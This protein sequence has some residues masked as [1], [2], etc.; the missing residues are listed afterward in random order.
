MT[1]LE[2]IATFFCCVWCGQV[3]ALVQ[4]RSTILLLAIKKILIL[5]RHWMSGFAIKIIT[6]NDKYDCPFHSNTIIIHIYI[7]WLCTQYY[8]AKWVKAFHWFI[9]TP[10]FDIN[11]NLA[12][13]SVIAFR[14]IQRETC[15]LCK[16]IWHQLNF[17][18]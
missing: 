12:V 2:E 6:I 13:L 18:I 15:H 1:M 8:T 7:S 17:W 9:A 11:H 3:D 4:K 14:K 16:N 5:I 10:Q